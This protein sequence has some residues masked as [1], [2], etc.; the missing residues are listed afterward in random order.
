MERI[1]YLIITFILVGNTGLYAQNTISINPDKTYGTVSRLLFGFNLSFEHDKDSLRQDPGYI[2]N[3]KGVKAGILRY[4]GGSKTSYY[5]WEYPGSPLR[6]DIY[7]PEAQD[8]NSK[9][10]TGKDYLTNDTHLD[11]DE[12]IAVYRA[13]GAEPLLGINIKSGLKFDRVQDGLEEARRWV[14]YCKDKGYNVKFW[15]LD[16]EVNHFKHC[17]A[18]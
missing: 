12:Y 17:V 16:N 6:K 15:Y 13:V 10:Y 9:F 11:T 8:P 4:P 5:H 14:Q 18:C 1:Q 2:E 3:L 7:H